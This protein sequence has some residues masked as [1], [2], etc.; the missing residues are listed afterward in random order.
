MNQKDFNLFKR[1]NNI[2]EKRNIHIF[3]NEFHSEINNLNEED[4]LTKDQK[5]SLLFTNTAEYLI[6][7][8][9][10]ISNDFKFIILSTHQRIIKYSQI[11]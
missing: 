3:P 1:F 7:H 11:S 9:Q 6:K 10:S 5:Q 2:I 8:I 4:S